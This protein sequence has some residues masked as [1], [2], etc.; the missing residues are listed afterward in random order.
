[1]RCLLLRNKRHRPMEGDA[2]TAH[3][4]RTGALG[5]WA[6]GT[7]SPFPLACATLAHNLFAPGVLVCPTSHW[8]GYDCDV[9][10][11]IQLAV[12]LSCSSSLSVFQS[13]LVSIE[14]GA[15]LRRRKHSTPFNITRTVNVTKVDL[16]SSAVDYRLNL[17]L[18]R[19]NT[20]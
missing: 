5:T 8:P 15:V 12:P 4:S 16:G 17:G 19:P 11:V 20:D 9:D 18:N 7:G 2:Q 13:G 6:L 14:S 10:N 3:R 1:M